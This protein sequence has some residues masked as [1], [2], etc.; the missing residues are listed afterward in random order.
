[1]FLWKRK[2][3]LNLKPQTKA[4]SAYKRFTNTEQLCYTLAV[5]GNFLQRLARAYRQGSSGKNLRIL[6]YTLWQDLEM[7][8]GGW[9]LDATIDGNARL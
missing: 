2:N 3:F 6:D 1:M 8:T 7:S 5:K 9:Q 4:T